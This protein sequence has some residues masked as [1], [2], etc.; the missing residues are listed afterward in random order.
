MPGPF[1]RTTSDS[2]FPIENSDGSYTFLRW[3]VE[4]AGLVLVHVQSL[5][6]L[7][8]GSAALAQKQNRV[9]RGA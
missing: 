2:E 3:Q 4:A 5:S 9:Y 7:S 8:G 1:V 6:V